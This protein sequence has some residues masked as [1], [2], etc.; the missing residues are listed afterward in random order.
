M[1]QNTLTP[2][3]FYSNMFSIKM[4]SHNILISQGTSGPLLTQ[5]T[6]LSGSNIYLPYTKEALGA[7]WQERSKCTFHS[8]IMIIYSV[9]YPSLFIVTAN[10][11]WSFVI[12]Y[13]GVYVILYQPTS[14]TKEKNGTA[15]IYRSWRAKHIT[16]FF[17]CSG[18]SDKTRDI[19]IIWQHKYHLFGY[20][21]GVHLS[22]FFIW[23]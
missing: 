22:P 21:W 16:T 6:P 14:T 11:S 10:L 12:F 3:K 2:F 5:M 4:T 17:F 19:I 1:G 18:Q 20:L 15:R 23:W 8:I 9:V 7:R 13:L